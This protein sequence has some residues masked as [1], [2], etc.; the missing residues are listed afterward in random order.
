MKKSLVLWVVV[1][2]CFQPYYTFGGMLSV[3]AEALKG[4]KA[5]EKTAIKIETVA[6][7]ASTMET[8]NL[9]MVTAG[10]LRKA[11]EYKKT[12]DK[13]METLSSPAYLAIVGTNSNFLLMHSVGS[14]PH[15]SEIDVPLNYA[16]YYFME[17]IIRY[18]KLISN[19]SIK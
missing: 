17:A 14:I 2:V 13:I 16:D 9:K 8:Q 5:V 6:K 3:F 12:A 1:L 7:P 15:G 18:K 4:G 11:S 19:Q 10:G